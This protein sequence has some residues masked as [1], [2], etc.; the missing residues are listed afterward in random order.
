MCLKLE[1]SKTAWIAKCGMVWWRCGEK[2]QLCCF[3]GWPLVG[4]E[5]MKLYM[6][7]R[8]WIPTKGQPVFRGK[9]FG[10]HLLQESKSWMG[11]NTTH[12]LM[13]SMLTSVSWQ[14]PKSRLVEGPY[15]PICRDCDCAI[16][17]SIT[18]Q[19]LTSYKS[20]CDSGN[21]RGFLR[22]T[23]CNCK[24]EIIRKSSWVEF[25]KII[26]EFPHPWGSYC[27]YLHLP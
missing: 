17:F 20:Q 10:S 15:T 7:M 5:G 27:T 21:F 18:V 16:Y 26:G 19:R 2:C 22:C 4:I 13:T 23:T 25:R 6:V 14:I 24:S 12:L 11:G 3:S 8:E 1:L 9:F